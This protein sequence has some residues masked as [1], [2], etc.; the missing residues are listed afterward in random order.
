MKVILHTLY[1]MLLI[2]MMTFFFL[3]NN[4]CGVCFMGFLLINAR[5]NERDGEEK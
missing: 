3:K 4:T 2:L 1:V 5:F